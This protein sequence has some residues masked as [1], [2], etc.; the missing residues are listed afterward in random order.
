MYRK[1]KSQIT[2]DYAS[3]LLADPESQINE[4]KFLNI[5]RVFNFPLPLCSSFS[6]MKAFEFINLSPQKKKI[7]Q[8]VCPYAHQE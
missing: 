1:W 5:F 2:D 6:K 7:Q 4:L 8:G 3:R